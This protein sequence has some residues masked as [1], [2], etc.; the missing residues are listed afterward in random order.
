MQKAAMTERNSNHDNE[1]INSISDIIISGESSIE[2]RGAPNAT[3]AKKFQ[4]RT[5]RKTNHQYRQ[6]VLEEIDVRGRK[7][8][9]T[10]DTEQ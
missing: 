9:T 4:E 3:S 7:N 8:N 1:N 5:L 10:N 6:Q 2:K